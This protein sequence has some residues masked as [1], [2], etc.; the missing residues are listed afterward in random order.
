MLNLLFGFQFGLIL[1]HDYKKLEVTNGW[2][3][4]KYYIRNGRFMM[5][6][7]ASVPFFYQA[8][9]CSMHIELLKTLARCR[10]DA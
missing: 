2:L 3:I 10:V 1:T 6:L 7:L 9:Y 8:S 5:D 4:A